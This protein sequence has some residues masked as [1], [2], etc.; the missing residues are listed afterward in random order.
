MLRRAL[1]VAFI[2]GVLL[3]SGGQEARAAGGKAATLQPLLEVLDRAKLSASLEFSGRC[4]LL[5][6]Q[7]FPD[8]PLFHLPVAATGS[9]LQTLRHMFTPDPAMQVTQSPSGVI[10]MIETGVPTDLLEVKIKHIS[11]DVFPSGAVYQ[12][13]VALR[14]IPRAPEI[15]DF[16]AAHNIEW[17]FHGEAVSGG[18]AAWPAQSPHISGSLDNL[19]L[20]DAL[21]IVLRTFPGIWIYE[22][23]PRSSERSRFVY[24]RFF[25]LRKIGS[26]K[27]FVDE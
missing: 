26:G 4:S 5:D 12:P 23:C 3:W 17:P 6:A 11:F 18:G 14:V 21:D 25:Y 2:I 1:T 16:M 24:L 22:S 27:P 13:N 10:R 9:P 19:T 7:D 15:V 8:F 20:S